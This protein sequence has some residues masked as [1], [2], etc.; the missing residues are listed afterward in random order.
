MAHAFSHGVG[1]V[2]VSITAF[3]RD[4]PSFHLHF[5]FLG[6]SRGSRGHAAFPTASHALQAGQCNG[7]MQCL[8]IVHPSSCTSTQRA[9]AAEN[10]RQSSHR[11]MRHMQEGGVYHT[12][13]EKLIRIRDAAEN[14][15]SRDACD[16]KQFT[17]L[18]VT[19]HHGSRPPAC[20]EVRDILQCASERN[21]H[22]SEQARILCES[23][24]A[25]M[26]RHG[27]IATEGVCDAGIEVISH[28]FQRFK[29]LEMGRKRASQRCGFHCKCE[30]TGVRVRHKKL[31]KS[32]GACRTDLFASR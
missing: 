14:L 9:H 2:T 28:N 22:S 23:A 24:R 27:R 12:A 1:L 21:A 5:Q 8:E 20:C 25:D 3:E 19:T 32:T 4:F 31:R 29:P 13:H 26:A 11:E 18:R 10:T 6:I 16:E 17:G 7:S 15:H 30:R